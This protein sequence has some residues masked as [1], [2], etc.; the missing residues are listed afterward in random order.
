V[1]FIVQE[2]RSF[3]Q[4]FGTFPG[5]DGFPAKNGHFTVCVPDPVMHDCA[6]PFH[7]SDVVGFGG[8]HAYADA[9]H[10]VNGGKMDGFITALH[11]PCSRYRTVSV[12]GQTLGPQGQPDIMGYH[13]AREIPNYWS[14]A[15]NFVLQDH[16]FASAE[17]WTL[18]SHLFLVSA[19]AAACTSAYN[20]MSCHSDLVQQGVVDKQRHG[21]HPPLYA[22]TD[23]TYLL[24]KDGISWAYYAGQNLCGPE[25]PS[26]RCQNG[27]AT[28]A[29]DPLPSFTDVQQDGQEGNVQTHADFLRAASNGT[30][31]QVSWVVPGRGGISEHPGTGAPLTKGQAYVTNLINT[32]MKGPD[33]DTTAIFLTWDDWGGFY[34]NLTPPHVD[35]NGYGLRVPGLLISPWAKAGMIDHQTLSFD[36]Y[37]K[38]IEFLFLKGQALDPKTDGRPD[39]RPTVR[40]KVKI[41]G[42]LRKEFDFHQNPIPPVIL[43]MNP[44]PGPASKPGG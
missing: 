18:P 22:W 24:H 38:F 23:I 21:A 25:V 14:Y 31:P 7:S 36:A 16:M 35:A 32:V 30:L 42:D 33:W 40:E 26:K 37:L 5:A 34:D 43:P 29:Q 1:I 20:P 12:C 11:D 44:P 3:D 28:P 17:S 8:P 41:L 10:D 2:N 9:V 6:Y 4:Y 13:D 39:S 15:H 19:W 27:G